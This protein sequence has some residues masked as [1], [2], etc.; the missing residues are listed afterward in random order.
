MYP[1]YS[2]LNLI[3]IT[4]FPALVLR[5]ACTASGKF[6]PQVSCVALFLW[7][8]IHCF[9]NPVQSNNYWDTYFFSLMFLTFV[10]IVYLISMLHTNVSPFIHAFPLTY[11]CGGIVP[12]FL[13]KDHSI[14]LMEQIWYP[15]GMVL[16]LLMGWFIPRT[17]SAPLELFEPLLNNAPDDESVT[18]PD[19]SGLP[20]NKI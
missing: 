2:I 7:S 17:H 12:L 15:T 6:I 13:I 18:G 1:I 14:F 11:L 9:Y 20:I 16:S 8:A 5:Q 10:V 19:E 3:T 4:I